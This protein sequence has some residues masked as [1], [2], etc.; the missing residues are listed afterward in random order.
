[1]H[2]V[3]YSLQVGEASH[4]SV[5]VV[6]IPKYSRGVHDTIRFVTGVAFESLQDFPKRSSLAHL[7]YVVKVVRHDNPRQQIVAYS[8]PMQ[9]GLFDHASHL[10]S[11]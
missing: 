5:A 6:W 10:R 11:S 1:M 4:E 8:I 2:I 3:D 9:E 7:E